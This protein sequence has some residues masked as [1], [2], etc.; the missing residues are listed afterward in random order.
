[1]SVSEWCQ[2]HALSRTD[3]GACKWAACDCPCGHPNRDQE[4]ED[5]NE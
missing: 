1:M 2:P 4:Q 5:T 3:H